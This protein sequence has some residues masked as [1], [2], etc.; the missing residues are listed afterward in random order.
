[1][2]HELAGEIWQTHEYDVFKMFKG[3]RPVNKVKVQRILES[4]Q[5]RQ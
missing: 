5:E 2:E 3:N 4:F 1:M